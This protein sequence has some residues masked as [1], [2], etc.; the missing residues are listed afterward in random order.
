[1]DDDM[2]MF[3]EPE[4][5]IVRPAEQLNLTEA[6]LK[7]EITRCLTGDNPNIPKNITKY[8]YQKREYRPDPPG[9]NEHM[10]VQFKIEG[11]SLHHESPEYVEMEKV[12]EWPGVCER[13]C[14]KICTKGH[15]RHKT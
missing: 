7:E 6:E 15:A 11:C 13:L 8:N 9:A 10:A 4:K 5:R 3:Q 12:S 1:M 14:D 2:D